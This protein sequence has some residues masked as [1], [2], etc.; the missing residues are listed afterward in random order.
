MLMKDGL[1][2]HAAHR[3]SQ[4]ISAVNLSFKS[5]EFIEFIESELEPLELKERVDLYIEAL[6]KY[7]PNNFNECHDIL[8]KIKP[9]W[10]YGDPNDATR[11]FAAW[12]VTDF[13]AKYGLDDPALSFDLM[14]ELTELFS[15][16]FA[17]R[18][19]IKQDVELVMTYLEQ[20][21]EHENHHVRRL[22]SEGTRPRLPWGIRLANFCQDPSPCLP[23]LD[24][25]RNDPSE[26][27][28]RSVANHLNDIAKDNPQI[29]IDT[30]NRWRKKASK[31]T[32]WV[33][34]HACRSLVKQGVADVFPLLGF[35]KNPKITLPNINLSSCD[36]HLGQ[37]LE[38][39]FILTSNAKQKQK[40]AID[41]V[42]HHIK[43]NGQLSA[44]VFKLK[45]LTLNAG[46]STHLVK[47]HAIKAITT[48]K[49]YAGKHLLEIQINGRSMVKTEFNLT[50]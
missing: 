3:I 46:E 40:L 19:F 28:R 33:I 25:L 45:E 31:E 4:A 11:S 21:V 15:A 44:K 17:I 49:Y 42:I 1:A 22:V 14:Q 29:V 20:W 13:V 6:A 48:R 32:L 37:T 34:K 47:R 24:K 2:I 9:H 36:I 50:I 43:A 41:F 10:D 5:T 38:F 12:P 35:A 27:V 26:Y 16:E 7:L 39:D 18:Y 30:C 8:M 23:L